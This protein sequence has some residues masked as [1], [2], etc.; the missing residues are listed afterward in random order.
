MK[1][2]IFPGQGSQFPG[3]GKDLYESDPQAKKLFD[4]ADE[5]LGFKISEI[6]F[7]GTAEQLKETGVTQPAVFIHSVVSAL[8]CADEKPDM[9]AGHS[10]GEIS[11]LVVCGALSFEDGL[12]LVAERASAM[13]EC[14]RQTAGTMAAVIALPDEKVVELC[15]GIDGVVAANFNCPGQVVISGTEQAV[16]TACEKMKEAGARRALVLPVSGAF[17]SPLMQQAS[18]RLASAI[19]SVTFN[20]PFCPIYQ[21][22]DA[23]AHTEPAQIKK[24]L[25]T[26]LTSSVRWTESVR[27]MISD[28]AEEFI[29]FGPGTVL[30]GLVSKIKASS[31]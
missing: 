1:A 30:T 8:C 14:C 5:I 17:H 13:Q 15:S 2:Y 21:N 26:Q 25:L 12:K 29:E 19:D 9:V 31:R 4:T 3:M 6:M 16:Q 20:T 24:N 22:V 7:N 23:Q 10:L 28:G 11:A 27:N 18:Q